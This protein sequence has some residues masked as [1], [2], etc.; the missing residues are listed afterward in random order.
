MNYSPGTT[1]VGS[2]HKAS[3]HQ[4][5]AICSVGIVLIL[6][7]HP[8]NFSLCDGKLMTYFEYGFSSKRENL[9]LFRLSQMLG[10]SS[11]IPG[12]C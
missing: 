1:E 5:R 12:H 9:I 8:P 11:P 4:S 2:I 10:N 6:L 3:F 7:L